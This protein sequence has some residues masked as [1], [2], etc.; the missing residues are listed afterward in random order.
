[1]RT[2]VWFL[3]FLHHF[4]KSSVIFCILSPQWPQISTATSYAGGKISFKTN[5]F[6]K[7]NNNN[8]KKTK[9]K[10]HHEIMEILETFQSHKPY[11]IGLIVTYI[12]HLNIFSCDFWKGVTTTET[13]DWKEIFTLKIWLN[14]SFFQKFLLF[15]FQF[16][17]TIYYALSTNI[18]IFRYL[19]HFWFYYSKCS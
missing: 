3:L 9:N 18:T 1:M 16:F 19:F 11:V 4:L 6:S 2:I 8:N 7:T 12:T 17:F 5:S 15:L 14:N 13:K 10:K